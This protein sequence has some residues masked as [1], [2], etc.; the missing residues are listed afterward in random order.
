M[1]GFTQRLGLVAEGIEQMLEALLAETPLPGEQIRPRRLLDA[2]RYASLAGGKR[3]RPFLV[4]ETAELLGARGAGV[5]RAATA[6]ELVH[7]YSLVHD[8]LPAMDDDDLRRGRPTVHK[9]FDE[10]TAILAGDGLLTYAF[11]VMA[12]P[13]THDDPAV[14]AALV[15]ALARASGIGGM[16]G[17]QAL[18]LEAEAARKPL[19]RSEIELLQAMK[20]GALLAVSVRAG[21]IIGGA[22]A[23]QRAALEQFGR[24]IGAAFQIA[25]DIL[26]E[27]GTEEQVGKRI[28]K[29]AERNKATL[30]R[31]LGL[32]GARAACDRLVDEAIGALS[33]FGAQADCLRQATRFV[34]ARSN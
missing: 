19:E 18:D 22:T 2:M 15:L 24:A 32:D 4:V 25:D 16:A 30:V 7:C 33:I 31:A 10:A 29:D 17:G 5:Y 9:A 28:G 1:G 8:D 13:A 3:L 27:T 6:V 11:D 23:E 26:D 34:A 14:R 12:D 21:A 20:T